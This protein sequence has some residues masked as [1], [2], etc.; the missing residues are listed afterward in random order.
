[1]DVD[2]HDVIPCLGQAR[3]CHQTDIA[4]TEYRDFHTHLQKARTIGGGPWMFRP[5]LPASVAPPRLAA[6]MLAA[7]IRYARWS[8]VRCR[9]AWCGTDWQRPACRRSRMRCRT[10][11]CGCPGY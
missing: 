6:A 3:P 11:P 2:T 8:S 1:V 10:R 7:A 5:G 9:P 4:C